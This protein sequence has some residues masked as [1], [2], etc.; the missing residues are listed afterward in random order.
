[1]P[2][3]P[4]CHRKQRLTPAGEGINEVRIVSQVMPSPD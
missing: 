1:L 3:E 2:P 4:P